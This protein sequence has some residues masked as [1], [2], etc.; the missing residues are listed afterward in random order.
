MKT[1]LSVGL[2]LQ[3]ALAVFFMLLFCLPLLFM[4][5]SSLKDPQAIFADVKSWKAFFPVGDVNF[6]QY[7]GVFERLPMAQFVFNS[8]LVSGVVV[9]AGLFVN[10]LAAFAIARLK[11]RGQNSLLV[12]L[13]ATLVIP[14][15]TIAMPLLVLVNSLPRLSWEDGSIEITIGWLNTYLV[16]IMPFIAGGFSIFLFVQYFKTLPKELDEAAIIDGASYFSIY[17]RIIVPL[18]GPAFATSAILSF[19]AIWNAY[20][21]PVMVVQ[22]EALRP[23]Q[24][25]LDYFWAST[26]EEGTQWGEIMAYSTLIT[27]PILII[28][29]IFQR[30]FVASVASSGVKG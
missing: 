9:I 7:L 6:D 2:V 21:W 26:S 24:V 11:F 25:G 12:F 4:I 10:S 1:K 17:W 14:F 29:V 3:Y 27:L 20:L 22:T 15:E 13:I 8:L 19:L 18:A 5:S 16:Q 30:A 28:F 23:V